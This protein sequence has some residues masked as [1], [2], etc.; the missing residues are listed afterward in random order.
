MFHLAVCITLSVAA[1]IFLAVGCYCS[2]KANTALS[3]VKTDQ[4]LKDPE[5]VV[6]QNSV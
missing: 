4:V 2:Y 6:S 1:L 5:R 3:N